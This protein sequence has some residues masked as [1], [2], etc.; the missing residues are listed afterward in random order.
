M[1]T[2]FGAALGASRLSSVIWAAIASDPLILNL[3]CHPW[4]IG[5]CAFDLRRLALLN[6][7]V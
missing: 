6:I 3:R 7:V 4:L 2:C 1:A 5:D